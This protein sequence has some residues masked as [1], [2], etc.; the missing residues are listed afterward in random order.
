[1]NRLVRLPA[2]PYF[3]KTAII[4]PTSVHIPTFRADLVV[5]VIEGRGVIIV[6]EKDEVILRGKAVELVAAAIDGVKTEQ[7]ILDQLGPVLGAPTI[8][9]CLIKLKEGGYIT[10]LHGHVPAK[11]QLF[12][13]EAGIDPDKAYHTLQHARLSIKTVGEVSETAIQQALHEL[14]IQTGEPGHLQLVLT[15]N[16]LNPTLAAIN[17]ENLA[18]KQ[19]WMLV[20]PVGREIWIGPLMYPGET[21]C[22]HCLQERLANQ[23]PLYQL[24]AQ[25]P[26]TP[27][28][29]VA[30]TFTLNA[31]AHLAGSLV[32]LELLKWFGMETQHPLSGAM[33]SYDIHTNES[34]LHTLTRRPQCPACGDPALANQDTPALPLASQKSQ[35]A[36]ANGYRLQAPEQTYDAFAHHISPITGIVKHVRPIKTPGDQ[37][38]V[39]SASHNMRRCQIY[40]HICRRC[41]AIR[42]PAKASHP[43][44]QKRAHFVKPWNGSRGSTR[45]PSPAFFL[46]T[47]N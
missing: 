25:D 35:R 14:A 11:Q 30:D 20:K 28:A 9:Y 13:M 26:E 10:A 3:R 5:K 40:R 7:E 45:V 39:Y 34:A 2:D 19:P 12:W 44:P 42:V 1:M 17:E 23:R 38:F 36:A 47:L 15:D 37:V 8:H 27:P 33:R 22:W 41:C 43:R 46:R 24:A 29:L 4:S 31:Q 16:Y 21:G 18:T 6:S 32:A